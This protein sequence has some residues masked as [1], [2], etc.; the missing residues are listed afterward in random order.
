MSMH[1]THI[2]ILQVQGTLSNSFPKCQKCIEQSMPVE[3]LQRSSVLVGT[4]K[5]CYKLQKF[6]T[7]PVSISN[8]NPFIHLQIKISKN[9]T[10]LMPV[11][12]DG[13]AGVAPGWL[14]PPEVLATHLPRACSS[15][16][17]ARHNLSEKLF[18]FKNR[19]VKATIQ[20]C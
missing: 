12:W 8:M 18:W 10:H 13:G 14:L 11:N 17:E 19:T 9:R 20:L 7:F 5:V 6:T 1:I 15:R 4:S 3:K 16:N 2:F